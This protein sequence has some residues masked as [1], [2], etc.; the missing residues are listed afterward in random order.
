[1]EKEIVVSFYRGG[2]VEAMHDDDI[3]LGFLGEQHVTRN[4]EIEFNKTEQVWQIRLVENETCFPFYF[5]KYSDAREFEIDW[6]NR[7]R[8]DNIDHASTVGQ[9]IMLG[10]LYSVENNIKNGYKKT[11]QKSPGR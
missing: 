6:L 10:L 1:M 5:K 8:L 9:M 11:A 4:C 2:S 3:S 7:C